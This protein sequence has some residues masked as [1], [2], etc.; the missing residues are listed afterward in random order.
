MFVEFQV[1]FGD[2]PGQLGGLDAYY[3]LPAEDQLGELQFGSGLVRAR[4]PMHGRTSAVDHNGRGVFHQ[5]ACPLTACR[6]HSLVLDDIVMSRDLDELSEWERLE[7]KLRS[8]EW[9]EDDPR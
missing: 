2:L 7:E 8:L 9:T 4:Q 5:L 3:I 6:Y 1:L